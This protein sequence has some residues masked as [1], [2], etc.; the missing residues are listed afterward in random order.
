M[1]PL[2]HDFTNETVLVFGGGPV[3]ARKARRFAREARVVVVSPEFADADFGDADRVEAAP[4]PEEV[5]GFV[6]EY[7]PALVV[8]ATDDSE[9]NDAVAAAGRDRGAMV[10]RADE[11][12]RE[13]RPVDEV[14]VPA[15]VR[16]GS[17]TVAVSTGGASPALS[18]HLRERIEAEIAGAGEMADLTADLRS[19]LRDGDYSPA[20]RRDAVRRVVRASSV[21]KALREGNAKPREEARNVIRDG[22]E[23]T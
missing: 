6:G 16:D 17:V 3:G 2:L 4:T 1:I 18:K 9:L 15:T 8:A 12:G 19:D 11:S 5:S 20:E 7:E 13:S 22:G 23:R 10:N 14:V 21:W